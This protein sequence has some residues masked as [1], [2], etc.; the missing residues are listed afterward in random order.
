[1]IIGWLLDAALLIL[2]WFLTPFE[3]LE[4]LTLPASL[5]I[6]VPVP[7]VGNSVGAMN[8]WFPVAVIVS[9][10]LV[11]G[12]VAQWIYNLIPFKAT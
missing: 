10:A 1:M 6:T 3:A 8:V 7:L 12:R 5:N 4:P 11:A 2:E 9:L